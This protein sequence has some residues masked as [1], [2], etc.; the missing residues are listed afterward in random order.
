MQ[1]SPSKSALLELVFAKCN[2]RYGRDFAD[3]WVGVTLAEVKDEWWRTLGPLLDHPD[4]IKYALE[5]L[6]DRPPTSAQFRDLCTHKPEPV[7]ERPRLNE[8]PAD[9]ARVAAELAKLSIVRMDVEAKAAG[10]N[11]LK[12]WALAL[13]DRELNHGAVLESG[14]KMTQA[15]RDMWRRALIESATT[16]AS[17]NAPF[18]APPFHLLP[19]GMQQAVKDGTLIRHPGSYEAEQQ[20]PT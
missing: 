4:S 6:P 12:A 13:R 14:R 16:F 18:Q 1:S 2:L 17:I 11:V 3:R 9:P 19:P 8:P 20:N 7:I 15:Q 5:T 10:G